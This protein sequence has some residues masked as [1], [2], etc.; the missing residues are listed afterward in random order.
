MRGSV[1]VLGW[2]VLDQFPREDGAAIDRVR[3]VRY[4]Q[5]ATFEPLALTKILSVL[6]DLL[7]DD[8]GS[9]RKDF[10]IGG[11]GFDLE[12]RTIEERIIPAGELVTILGR[13][14]EA[15]RGFAP[16]GATSINRIFPGDLEST[17]RQVGGT[18]VKTFGAGL[19]FFI[20]LHALLVPM[21]FLAPGPGATQSSP[22][23]SVWDERDCDR[24]KTLLAAGANANESGR[25][26]LTPLMNAAREGQAACVENLIAAGARLDTTDKDGDTALSQAVTAGRAENVEILVAAGAK[27]F[28]VTA[29]TGRPIADGSA[30]LTAVKDYIAAVHRGDFQT[31]ARL[32]AGASVAVMEERRSD[33]AFWQSMRPKSSE[34]V[35]GWMNDEEATLTIHGVTPSGDHRVSYHL[36]HREEG[37]RIKREWFPDIR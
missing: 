22:P 26:G 25:D 27:D 5:A 16:A 20:A 32:M 29:K 12:G 34:L 18:A 15:R 24:Q 4:L 37:W 19:A 30:P 35:E 8:D 10:R 17:R 36:E 21:Y 23:A 11:E 7:T 9:I 6:G 3:G 1:S 28:R 31:M 13:W 33:L 2:A 14:S